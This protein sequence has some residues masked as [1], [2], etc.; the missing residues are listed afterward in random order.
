MASST[1]RSAQMIANILRTIAA[2]TEVVAQQAPGAREKMLALSHQ[3]TSALET[4]S[5]TIQRMGWAEVRHPSSKAYKTL[6]RPCA[7]SCQPARF[8]ATQLAVDLKIFEK[9]E[10]AHDAPVSLS[11]LV[12]STG[13]EAALIG[14]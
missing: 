4:P 9:L 14:G 1:D 12:Q 6:M 11:D 13:A 8:A 5:E 10:E 3:L 2:S 7:K